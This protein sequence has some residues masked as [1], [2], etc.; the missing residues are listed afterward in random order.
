MYSKQ[1]ARQV[2]GFPGI[3]ESQLWVIGLENLGHTISYDIIIC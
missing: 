3:C 1:M 2:G